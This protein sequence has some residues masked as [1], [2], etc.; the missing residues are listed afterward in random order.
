MKF[1]H[2]FSPY[3]IPQLELIIMKIFEKF[4]KCTAQYHFN[5]YSPLN[6]EKIFFR[7]LCNEKICSKLLG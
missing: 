1:R 5:I 2:E 7:L 6:E 4:G 3:R